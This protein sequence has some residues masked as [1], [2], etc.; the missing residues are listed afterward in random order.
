MA[1]QIF[2][3]LLEEK[4][5]FFKSSF[6][7]LAKKIF[8]DK[9]T[10]KLIH[11]GEYGMYRETIS[12]EFIRFIIPRRLDIEQGFIICPNGDVSHQCDIVVFD[13]QNT[14][15]IE[16][17]EKQRFFPVEIVAAIGEIKSNLD[18]ANFKKAINKLSKVK[19]IRSKINS[20]FFIKREETGTYDTKQ[21][22]KD[23]IVTFLICQKLD[24]NITD[25]NNEIEGLY[26]DE[27]K[28]FKHN[29]I[30]S[31]EDGLL[32]YN[33]DNIAVPYQFSNSEENQDILIKSDLQNTHFKVFASNLFLTTSSTTII[34]PQIANYIQ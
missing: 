27:N 24:F 19:K 26:S 30:L 15:M 34:F 4:I 31:I 3:A 20:S 28:D 1:N 8:V 9:K 7:S 11:P 32:L 21:N 14:P 29:L 23:Q 2:Q 18:K 33:S 25:I 6:S 17:G 5:D 12:K 22:K 16:N 10:G 13:S